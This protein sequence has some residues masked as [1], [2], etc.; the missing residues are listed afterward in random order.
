MPNFELSIIFFLQIAV[1]LA[2][3][4][5]VGWIGRLV[6]QSQ[7]VGEMIAGVLLG[8]SLLGAFW[9]G[10][11]EAL[12]PSQ[13]RAV[14]YCVAQ[15]GLALY[16]FVVG[17]EFRTDILRARVRSAVSISLAGIVTPFALGALLATQLHGDT[18]YF[19]ADLAAWK[20]AVFMGAAMSITAFPMLARIIVEQRLSGTKVGTLA[21]AAGS[22]DDALAWCLLA[23][24]LAG[25]GGSPAVAVVAIGGGAAYAAAVLTIGRRLLRRLD[26]SAA[27]GS[28][29]SARGRAIAL[30]ESLQQ[31]ANGHVLRPGTL[32]FV[33]ILLALASWYTDRIGIYAVFG[34][35]ILGLAMPRGRFNERVCETLEPITSA[36]LLPMFFVY[37]GLNTRITLVDSPG[38]WGLT[39]LV[40]G[41]ACVGKGG[42]CWAAARLHGEPPRD[43]AAIGALMNARGLMELIIL[44]IG[45][46]RGVITPTLF[47][48]M[49]IMAIVTTLMAT[50]LF[51]MTRGGLRTADVVT[52]ADG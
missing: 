40:L 47:S 35:F 3:C 12:F 8:P 16:M 1:I 28:H 45:L 49:V 37:S 41:A 18:R 38:L 24:V 31:V 7:V 15:V 29:G 39:L 51:Q 27:D 21:L 52:P 48:I 46:E 5:V 13:S 22:I 10:V 32:A 6:G 43:A 26:T 11:Y 20:A 23:V 19:G 42:A 2:A 17:L 4:R 34:A 44:N 9:P 36:L 33:L 25:L 50:P 14:I 30:D